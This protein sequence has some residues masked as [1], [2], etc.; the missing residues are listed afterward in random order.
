VSWGWI[1]TFWFLA[2]VVAGPLVGR[3]LRLLRPTGEER[4]RE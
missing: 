2:A 4:E 1:V 3:W